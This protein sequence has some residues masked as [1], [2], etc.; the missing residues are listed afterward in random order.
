MAYTN[1]FRVNITLAIVGNAV[2][3]LDV[4]AVQLMPLGLAAERH[5]PTL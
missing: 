4:S 2:R 1:H 5:M 3:R